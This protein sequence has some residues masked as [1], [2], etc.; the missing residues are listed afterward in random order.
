MKTEYIEFDLVLGNGEKC[1]VRYCDNRGVALFG[2]RTIHV[3][4][5]GC[6]S[7]SRTLYRSEFRVIGENEKVDPSTAAKEVIES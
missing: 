2:N 1:K 5:L 7:V 6:L 3:E 4:F